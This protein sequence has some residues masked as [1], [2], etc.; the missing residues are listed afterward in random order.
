MRTN[1][2]ARV[3]A[4]FCSM[5]VSGFVVVVESYLVIRLV[6]NLQ[7][8]LQERPENWYCC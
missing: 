2:L 5:F 1:A 8:D 4:Y 7:A 6:V 3:K